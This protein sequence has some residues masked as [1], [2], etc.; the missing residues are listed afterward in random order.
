[1]D[2]LIE[3]VSQVLEQ[4][5]S[6]HSSQAPASA[7]SG[8]PAAG[9]PP[10]PATPPSACPDN[11]VA[12]ENGGS[13]PPKAAEAPVDETV[14][15]ALKRV[16]EVIY[17]GEMFSGNGFRAAMERRAILSYEEFV[18]GPDATPS[19]PRAVL[20]TEDL[21]TLCAFADRLSTRPRDRAVSHKQALENC[22]ESAMKLLGT[23]ATQLSLSLSLRISITTSIHSFPSSP[24]R[25]VLAGRGRFSGEKP[26]EDV[27]AVAATL[28]KIYQS[29]YFIVE[30]VMQ[31]MPEHTPSPA[32]APPAPQP[33]ISFMT[34][35][36]ILPPS[37]STSAAAAAAAAPPPMPA[38]EQVVLEH[39]Q[40]GPSQQTASAPDKPAPHAPPP[41]PS[42][43][44]PSPPPPPQQPT[45][46]YAGLSSK[47]AAAPWR[48]GSRKGGGFGGRRGGAAGA[49]R[50][51]QRT[52]PPV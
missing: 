25:W 46:S 37:S 13:K 52:R 1:M 32:V 31:T 47:P 23:A 40:P 39:M 48:G 18:D 12:A 49:G 33:D 10:A 17:F 21:D 45:E 43:S 19:P 34:E 7:A 29:Q 24:A 38:L 51:S 22:L 15:S 30:P 50:Y 26:D 20:T 44:S 28:H 27:E 42:S 4:A 35:S 6:K 41:P 16:L 9:P 14:A 5:S 3:S 2:A 36:T 11:G 8:P